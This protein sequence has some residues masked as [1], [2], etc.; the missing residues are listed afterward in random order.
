M[1]YTDQWSWTSSTDLPPQLRRKDRLFRHPF[2]SVTLS[3][4]QLSSAC[5]SWRRPGF[6]IRADGGLIRP[7]RKV[8]TYTGRCDACMDGRLQ[9]HESVDD[10][11][12]IADAGVTISA[13][14]D[15]TA[16][17]ASARPALH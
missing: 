17:D 6:L 1:K 2:P 16:S 11:L 13:T 10:W 7:S 15:G 12:W 4:T 9:R 5:F 3:R 8:K 14:C